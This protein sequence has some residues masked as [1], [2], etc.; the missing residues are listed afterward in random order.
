MGSALSSI[1]YYL[2]WQDVESLEQVIGSTSNIHQDVTQDEVDNLLAVIDLNK[3]NYVTKV[4]LQEYFDLLSSKIDQNNDGV[5]SKTELEGYVE[6]KLKMSDKEL[7]KWKHSYQVL[8]EEYETLKENLQ[9]EEGRVLEVSNISNRVLKDY[10]QNEI[11]DTE[12]NIKMLPDVIERRLYL[13]LY[14]TMLKSIEKLS[15][16]TAFDIL[17]HRISF[18]IQ[19][20]LEDK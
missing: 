10:I 2:G 13:K 12:S 11:I 19:P 6:S 16:K 17:G 14:K 1:Q 7:E 4:E 3:D 20:I 15:E 8:F 5:V 18:A 9:M